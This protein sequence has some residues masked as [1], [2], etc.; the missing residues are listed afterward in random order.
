MASKI[1]LDIV[2]Q[3]VCN[4]LCV[5]LCSICNPLIRCASGE[6]SAPINAC[7]QHCTLYSSYVFAVSSV[8]WHVIR[9]FTKF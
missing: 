9:I 5:H 8:C 1:D 2:Y 3:L 6:G 7:L 4:M